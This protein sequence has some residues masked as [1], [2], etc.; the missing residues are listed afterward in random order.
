MLLPQ[1]AFDEFLRGDAGLRRQLLSTLLGLDRVE[2]IQRLASTRASEL[3][4]EA[5]ARRTLLTTEYQDLAPEAL[6]RLEGEVEALV[7]AVEADGR[8]AR[9]LEARLEDWRESSRLLEE[10]ARLLGRRASLQQAGERV[11]QVRARAEAARRA[12]SVMPHL[13]LV[14]QA[15]ERAARAEAVM[16]ERAAQLSAATEAR[17]PAQGCWRQ[18]H[19][20]A[21]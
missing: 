14:A 18:R 4:G 1:G 13:Q 6:K 3:K 11:A 17:A 7:A 10:R 8:A 21:R 9:E 5:E 15:G 2:S 19:Q 16:K 12:A 20:R